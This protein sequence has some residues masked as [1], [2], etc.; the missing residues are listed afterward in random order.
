MQYLAPTGSLTINEMRELS[1]LGAI[2]GGERSVESLN[3]VDVT[4]KN[5]YLGL[6]TVITT[7]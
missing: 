4:I 6:K 7:G 2:D 1:G 5:D 3:F